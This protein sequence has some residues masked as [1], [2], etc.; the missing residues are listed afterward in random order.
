MFYDTKELYDIKELLG[1]SKEDTPQDNKLMLLLNATKNRLKVRL[2]GAE[3]PEALN[4]IIVDVVIKRF[5]RIG[6]EGLASHSVEGES[7]VFAEDDFAE[8]EDDIQA[9]LDSLENATKG[10]VRF[11]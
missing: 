3:P 11:L 5:N 2:G 1:I 9:Y 4:Y 10:K 8:Y 6:S 7:Q